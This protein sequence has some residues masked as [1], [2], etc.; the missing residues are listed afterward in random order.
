MRAAV[1][2][3]LGLAVI[4]LAA[5]QSAPTPSLSVTP[6]PILQGDPIEIKVAGLAPG[7]PVTLTLEETKL[8]RGAPTY[9]TSTATFTAAPDGTVSTSKLAP[10]SGGYEGVDPAGLFWSRR[11]PDAQQPPE[12]APLS[13]L[14]LRV[15]IA[16]DETADFSQTID[17]IEAPD[18]LDSAPLGDAFPGAFAVYPEGEGPHPVVFI[19]GGSE[20][21][22]S[23]ARR[24]APR[25]AARGYLAI[26]VPY[27]S[28]AWG[29]Q[30]QAIPGL[31]R[32]FAELPVDYLESITEHVKAMPGADPERMGL[33]G[34]SKGAEYVLLA[35][36]LI[37]GYE[38]IAAIV[39]TDVVWEGWGADTTTSSF[40][41]RGEALPF[42][43]YKGMQEEFQKP[44]PELR[45]PHDAGRDAN[46]ERVAPARIP[47]EDIAAPVFLVGGD[48]D[49]VWGSG[50]MA[51]TIKETRDSAGLETELIVSETAGHGLSG[52]GYS[53]AF[54]A[55]AEV[56]RDAFP[57]M[58]DFFERHLKGT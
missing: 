2:G 57:A 32:A 13:P 19:L 20:G 12:T 7:T 1:A 40:S 21:N 22:D 17:I 30:P 50:P 36:H 51:R 35:G 27:Y 26:G 15:D 24:F 25:F 56:K 11:R 58:L 42:V 38:A 49:T 39:P 34:V 18:G 31:P 52:D 54:Q 29:N 14:T 44:Q 4:T 5:C 9:Y 16:A 47:V 23:S 10:T 37:G 45:I 46:P 41:W 6:G 8:R 43:P 28:P 33:W 53:P 3:V 55:E 48:A